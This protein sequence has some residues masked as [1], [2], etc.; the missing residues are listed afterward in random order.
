MY[1]FW[2]NRPSLNCKNYVRG[3][4]PLDGD[5]QSNHFARS[6]IILVVPGE[7]YAGVVPQ[8][9]LRNYCALDL[10]AVSYRVCK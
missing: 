8:H 7:E 6:P 3:Q 4:S 10:G 9:P 1:C 2:E 5:Y